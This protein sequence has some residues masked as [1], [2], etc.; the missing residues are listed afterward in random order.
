MGRKDGA[1]RGITDASAIALFEKSKKELTAAGRW[2]AATAEMLRSAAQWTQDA[3][4]ITS[5][6]R[7]MMNGEMG[8]ELPLQRLLKNRVL[9]EGERD[10]ILDALL[11][12][13]QKPRGRPPKETAPEEDE[14]DGGWAAFDGDEGG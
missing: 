8:S 13:P 10:R 5:R 1:L 4:D 2:N 6:I 3:A 14:D 12:T 7:K 11:L 9:C